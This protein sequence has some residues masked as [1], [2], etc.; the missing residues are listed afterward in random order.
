MAKI[1]SSKVSDPRPRI[2]ITMTS[3]DDKT[4][5]QITRGYVNVQRGPKTAILRMPV[6]ELSGLIDVLVE[7]RSQLE[8]NG[9]DT[10]AGSEEP[11]AAPTTRARHTADT[12]DE[13]V[14]VPEDAS[15]IP[16]PF[17]VAQ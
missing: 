16:N 9:Y 11:L 6:G 12:E 13:A 3:D 8:Q 15:S 7:A 17:A 10:T 14:E 2:N 4:I 1:L 5:A